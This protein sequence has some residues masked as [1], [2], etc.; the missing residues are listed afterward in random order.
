MKKLFFV[1]LLSALLNISPA[2]AITLYSQTPV[3]GGG[4]GSDFDI[5]QFAYSGL[6]LGDASVIGAVTWRG[7]DFPSDDIV[8]TDD[9]TIV[10]FL[11][12]G[13]AGTDALGA[14]ITRF[15]V[16][17]AVNRIDTGIDVFA[18]DI[19]EYSVNLSGGL[20]LNAGSYFMAIVNNTPTGPGNWIWGA[21]AGPSLSLIAFNPNV[22]GTA[23]FSSTDEHYFILEGELSAVPLPAALPLSRS[24]APALALWAS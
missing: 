23:N 24:S 3:V 4:I 15:E 10:F 9:F 19:F 5:P 1:L 14:E 17:N 7:F 8:A 2:N 20:G 6:T 13:L 21:G 12:T 22:L 11:N 18:R 16:G